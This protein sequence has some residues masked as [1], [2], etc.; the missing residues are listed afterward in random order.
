MTDRDFR[1]IILGSS[2]RFQQD[3]WFVSG[4]WPT[5]LRHFK[6]Q[7]RAADALLRRLLLYF[8]KVVWPTNNVLPQGVDPGTD[9]LVDAGEVG[10]VHKNFPELYPGQIQLLQGQSDAFPNKLA[11]DADS[12]NGKLAEAVAH[13]HR[14]VY[15]RFDAQ[16]PGKWAYAMVGDGVEFGPEKLARGYAMT[17]YNL[18]PTP[19][20][21]ASFEDIIEFKKHE[22]S[23]LLDMRGE[24]DAMYIQVASCDDKDFALNV[25]TAKVKKA[26]ETVQVLL[27]QRRFPWA[28]QSVEVDLNPASLASAALAADDAREHLEKWGAPPTWSTAAGV[29]LAAGLIIKPK[30]V[31]TLSSR[32]GVYLYRYAFNAGRDEILDTN[33]PWVAT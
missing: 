13:F 28:Y 16:D 8:D 32:S 25:H 17:L 31:P 29:A 2:W 26:I 7:R 22:R 21:L 27:S 15:E 23:A 19:Q 9:F 14:S 5:Q 3:M 12:P 24:L 1:G 10:R 18:L 6:G 11:V 33:A 4:K 30:L 20:N